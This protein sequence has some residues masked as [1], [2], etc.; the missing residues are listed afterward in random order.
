MKLYKYISTSMLMMALGLTACS[1]QLDIERHGAQ[2]VNKYYKTDAQA[3]GS[4]ATIYGELTDNNWYSTDVFMTNLTSDDVYTGGGSRGDSFAYEEI[5]EFRHATDNSMIS[6]I[7]STYYKLVYKCNLTINKVNPEESATKKRCVA[8]AKVLRAWAYL[9]LACTFGSCPVITDV[10]ESGN[11]QRP[12]NTQ[13]ELFAQVEKDLTEAIASSA[14]LEKKNVDDQVVNVTKQTA[15]GLLGK[16][17]VYESTYLNIDKWTE[18]RKALSEVINSGKYALYKGQYDN[19]WHEVGRFSCESMLETNHYRDE[20]NMASTWGYAT[21]NY[22]VENLNQSQ[23]TAANE[24]GA[25]ITSSSCWGFFYPTKSLYDAFVE[26]EGVDG[27]RLNRTILTYKKMS[28]YPLSILNGKSIYGC[29]GYFG[30]KLAARKSDEI[31]PSLWAKDCLM[32]RYAEVLLLAAEAELPIHG[33]NQAKV[34]QYINEI[35]TRAHVTKQPGNYTL[36]DIQKE[37]RL[38]LCFEGSRFFD[39]VRWGLASN[40]LAEKGKKIPSLYGLA[41]G[42]DNGNPSFENVDG[43]N[44]KYYETSSEGYKMVKND[45]YPI[46]LKELNVNPYAKQHEGW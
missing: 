39:L 3:L 34:D 13:A 12:N 5:N 23:L 8:E 27:Y 45:F 43:Y 32:F 31:T 17:Y 11:Y 29:E 28:E 46:P 25:D 36:K 7:Y 14:L 2:L 20:Q 37:K 4:L 21:F 22:R 9:R 35:R 26:E 18:A 10:Q 40:A 33:G 24:K 42:T 6:N 15:Q 41:N 44:V 30:L 16:A 38:E 1:N 19:M